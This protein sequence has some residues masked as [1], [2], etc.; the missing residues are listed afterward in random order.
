MTANAPSP[1]SALKHFI[2]D[3]IKWKDTDEVVAS[4][5]YEKVLTIQDMDSIKPQALHQECY[6][7]EGH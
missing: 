2:K 5:A 4:L 3:V 7:M 1:E 6:Q